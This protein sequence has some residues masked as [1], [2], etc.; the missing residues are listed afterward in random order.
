MEEIKLR[1]SPKRQNT[2]NDSLFRLP[3]MNGLPGSQF[4]SSETNFDH[5]EIDGT[6]P[7]GRFLRYKSYIRIP[8]WFPKFWQKGIFKKSKE[9]EDLDRYI[10]RSQIESL[11]KTYI[12]GI[13]FFIWFIF[14]LWWI[15][16]IIYYFAEL[17]ETKSGWNFMVQWFYLMI[18]WVLCFIIVKFYV[19]FTPFLI[20]I[21]IWFFLFITVNIGW[22]SENYAITEYML[23]VGLLVSILIIIV[24]SQWLTNSFAF[25]LGMIYFLFQ[26]YYHYKT[27]PVPLLW[28]VW[29]SSMYFTCAAWIL[30]IKLRNLYILLQQNQKLNK[31]MKRLLQI[32]PESVLIKFM[33]EQQRKNS[34][35]SAGIKSYMEK[36]WF[37]NQKFSSHIW[38]IDKSIKKLEKFKVAIE[39]KNQMDGTSEE[40]TTTLYEFLENQ[41]R[42]L[43]DSIILEENNVKVWW[44]KEIGR[45]FNDS[46]NQSIEEDDNNVKIFNIKTLQVNWEGKG[47][48]CM[49]VFIDTTDIRRLE[50]ATNNIKC[51]KIMFASVSHEF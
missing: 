11:F 4:V 45:R 9:D 27:L 30:Y 40:I 21:S 51:Q 42:R 23:P 48:A 33:N 6:S 7:R 12:G 32:F 1:L 5:S 8:E 36:S 26:I 49:H 13:T 46:P 15:L 20:P 19:N 28:S 18:Y 31:E 14:S 25:N 37:T 17:H 39:F 35:D 44:N 43:Q 3:T 24:P 29:L 2:L 10:L 47:D 22:G 34:D 16:N 38:E 41:E 50:E